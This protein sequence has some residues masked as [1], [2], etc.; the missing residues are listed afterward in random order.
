MQIFFEELLLVLV[1]VRY[2]EIFYRINRVILYH[3]F[4]VSRSIFLALS[5]TL[6]L[7]LS[8]LLS[9]YISIPFTLYLSS[10]FSLF[11]SS[12]FF[13]SL[14]LFFLSFAFANASYLTTNKFEL[15]CRLFHFL[16][17]CLSSLSSLS[18]LSFSLPREMSSAFKCFQKLIIFLSLSLSVSIYLY[19]PSQHVSS[20]SIHLS[21]RLSLFL[22]FHILSLYNIL[23]S[24]TLTQKQFLT[25][26]CLI[27]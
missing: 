14:S 21:F 6:F 27:S 11:R 18:S 9:F 4:F 23:L 1:F 22:S 25:Y 24:S 16:V 13:L 2:R 19:L 20:F 17:A 10:N 5:P 7:P 26:V 3:S 8:L 15:L 12:S